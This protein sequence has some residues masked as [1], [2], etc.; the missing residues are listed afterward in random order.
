MTKCLLFTFSLLVA[1][2]WSFTAVAQT[3]GL[4]DMKQIFQTAPQ[5]KRINT[6]LQKQFAPQQEEI[7]KLTRL[8]QSDLQKLKRDEAVMS[9]KEVDRLHSDIQ[10]KEVQLRQERQEF[11]QKLFT[12]Q[13][14]GM[15][16]FI[17]K[18]SGAVK[19][20]AE[21]EHF[22]LV[23]PKDLVL[24]AKYSK[25]VTLHVVSMLK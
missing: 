24:Y 3:I 6:Q 22:D 7:T 20:V 10:K 17:T 16:D 21:K 15:G 25:D 1:L 14:N 11:Q 2:T 4:V 13:N 19:N 18:I 23:L 12:A 5:I 8:L 9:K